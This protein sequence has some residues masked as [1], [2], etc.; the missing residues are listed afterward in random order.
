[1]LYTRIANCLLESLKYDILTCTDADIRVSVARRIS[2][3]IC[4]RIDLSRLTPF[5][6]RALHILQALV[7]LKMHKKKSYQGTV[8][9]D[10]HRPWCSHSQY[11]RCVC[12]HLPG[13]C[14]L[15]WRVISQ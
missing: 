4:V 8:L 1:M 13:K 12:I 3:A 10:K 9:L 14:M 11:V 7:A 6:R 2:F 15:F 5:V